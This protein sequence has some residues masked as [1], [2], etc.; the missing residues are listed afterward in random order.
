[1]GI[2]RGL[3]YFQVSKVY[4]QNPSGLR[5]MQWTG[6][7]TSRGFLSLDLPISEEPTLGTWKIKADILGTEQVQTFKVEEYGKWI[8]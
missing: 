2:I 5:V 7:Q 1:M 4:V 8:R 3:L 6:L